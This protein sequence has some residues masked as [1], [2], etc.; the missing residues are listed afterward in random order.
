MLGKYQGFPGIVKLK[1]VGYFIK[2]W[3]DPRVFLLLY[4]HSL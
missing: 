1:L 2:Y 3:I 4:L